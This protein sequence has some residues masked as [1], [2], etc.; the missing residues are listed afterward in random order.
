MCVETFCLSRQTQS[1]SP[2]RT[3]ERKKKLLFS[4]WNGQKDVI[5]V[6]QSRRLT[7]D[8]SIKKREQDVSWTICKSLF[9][10]V[11]FSSLSKTSNIIIICTCFYRKQSNLRKRQ[12][13]LD[14]NKQHIVQVSIC[15]FLKIPQ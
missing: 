5:G 12:N 10:S 4:S 3:K 14:N 15:L 8:C 11:R 1:V 6:S 2:S 13:K 9:I 7:L